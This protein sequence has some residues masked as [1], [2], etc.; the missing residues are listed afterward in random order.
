MAKSTTLR[1]VLAEIPGLAEA[2]ASATRIAPILSSME[3]LPRPVR[4][5]ILK[6]A[7]EQGRANDVSVKQLTSDIG[8]TVVIEGLDRDFLRGPMLRAL[9]RGEL[10]RAI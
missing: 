7:R 3:K 6:T 8:A 2:V 10:G 9:E 1:E 4:A 5:A